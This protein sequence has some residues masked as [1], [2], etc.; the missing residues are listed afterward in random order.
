MLVQL[1]H[2]SASATARVV[3]L[4]CHSVELESCG[5]CHWPN[6]M[7]PV[8]SCQCQC[9]QWH[10]AVRQ[11]QVEWHCQ[12][13]LCW[14]LSMRRWPTTRVNDE[15]AL[16]VFKFIECLGLAVPSVSGLLIT[17]LL[18]Y[19][20]HPIS[21]SIIPIHSASA[22]SDTSGLIVCTTMHFIIPCQCQAVSGIGLPLSVII[23][24]QRLSHWHMTSCLTPSAASES[25][26]EMRG[27][28]TQY[29][30]HLEVVEV[31]A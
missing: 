15:M 30:K 31:V 26:A 25:T 14:Q 11:L 21:S 29:H 17:E 13:A 9:C 16:A 2:A 19:S 24:W 8:P 18:L 20:M 23:L 12:T 28:T 5:S 6:G 7:L 4:L 3:V 22:L 27:T 1:F 10:S